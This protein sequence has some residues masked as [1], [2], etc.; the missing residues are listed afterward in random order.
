MLLVVG[1][2]VVAASSAATQYMCENGF[3]SGV[4]GGTMTSFPCLCR[5]ACFTMTSAYLLPITPVC[6]F[7]LKKCIGVTDFSIREAMCSR[8]LE[9]LCLCC[10]SGYKSCFLIWD[11]EHA[12]SVAMS[13]QLDESAAAIPVSSALLMVLIIPT[14]P[15]IT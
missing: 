14:P 13:V 8:R 5:A 4:G 2:A 10:I 9:F 6:A 1:Q 12:L 15:E 7:T 3:P 11:R